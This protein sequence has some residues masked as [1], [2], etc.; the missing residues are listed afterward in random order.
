M[1][2]YQSS[3]VPSGYG[4]IGT[5]GYATEAE[6]LEACKEGACCN[7]STCSVKPQCQCDESQG[8]GFQGVGTS[9]SPNPC[10]VGSCCVGPAC[11]QKSEEQC[12]AGFNIGTFL[13]PNIVQGVFLGD[14]V[15]CDPSPC[16]PTCEPHINGQG[17]CCRAV[18]VDDG[19]GACCPPGRD[20][21]GNGIF[22]ASGAENGAC[23][24]ESKPYCCEAS[25]GTAIRQQCQAYLP[26]V[27]G[28]GQYSAC[29]HPER[30]FSIPFP[31]EPCTVQFDFSPSRSFGS[32]RYTSG[33]KARLQIGDVDTVFTVPLILSPTGGGDQRGIFCK[34]PGITQ[35]L[36]TVFD[37]VAQG[38]DG[39]VT[40]EPEP[41]DSMDCNVTPFGDQRPSWTIS[42]GITFACDCNPL[43]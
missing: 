29:S 22:G 23:C 3:N 13:E 5:G 34:P 35:A 38:S 26:A 30:T 21:C 16:C 15:P 37:V 19:H 12:A 40:F 7:G 24:P 8:F 27:G 9:C 25:D 11:Y 4:K 18:Y 2:C 36:I 6:C 1:P 10:N 31:S 14:N 28:G 20:C 39:S 43:P 42:G 32:A 33:F 41:G 17:K